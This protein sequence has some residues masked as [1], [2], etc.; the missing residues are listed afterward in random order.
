MHRVHPQPVATLDDEA[1]AEAYAISDP[2]SW[3]RD[4]WLRVNFVMSLDGAIVGSEGLSK[5]LGTDA[6][7]RVF[8]LARRLC[9]VVLVGAGTLRLEDY[10]PSTRPLAIVSRRLDLEPSLRVFAERG[11]EHVRPMIL[12]TSAAIAGA[13]DWLHSEAD[14]VDCGPESVSL[15]RAITHLASLDLRHVLC[16]GGPALLTD[17][18]EADLVDELL[19]TIAPRLVGSPEHLVHRPGGFT[20]PVRLHLAEVLEHEGTVLTRYLAQNGRSA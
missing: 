19:L 3:S 11:A 9:D 20:P 18:V 8:H 16:E 12:T 14:L 15:P 5:S 4:V 13:P 6:D 2:D 7:R 10:R 17:L 1:L